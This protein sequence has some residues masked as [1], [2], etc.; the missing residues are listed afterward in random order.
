MSHPTQGAAECCLNGSLTLESEGAVLA[1]GDQHSPSH[2]G[3]GTAGSFKG[4]R[5][6]FGD[7]VSVLRPIGGLGTW[8]LK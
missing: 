5:S 2:Q 4:T 7:R 1:E 6:P 8:S 3:P